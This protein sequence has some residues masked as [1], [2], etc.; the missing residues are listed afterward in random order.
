MRTVI[1]NVNE[2]SVRLGSGHG[3][4]SG[5][6]GERV[7]GRR[8]TEDPCVYEGLSAGYY[9]YIY[10]LRR[11][12][13][14]QLAG[15][16]R[17]EHIVSEAPEFE[18]VP[19]LEPCSCTQVC[20]RELLEEFARLMHGAYVVKVVGGYSGFDIRVQLWMPLVNRSAPQSQ[21]IQQEEGCM[22]WAGYA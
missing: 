21:V 18:L 11:E 17:L 2:T 6:E 4:C 16:T 19:H 5:S 13:T 7:R 15:S 1:I 12:C 3:A 22:G 8:G 10:A 14:L 20:M 9:P